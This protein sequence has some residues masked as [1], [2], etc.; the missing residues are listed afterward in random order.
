M[1]KNMP[2]PQCQE[3]YPEFYED[4][5]EEYDQEMCGSFSPKRADY[6]KSY[7]GLRVF[8]EEV[9]TGGVRAKASK[10]KMQADFA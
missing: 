2:N 8:D 7:N 9:K 10:K 1:A 3:G 5:I 4:Q 6:G